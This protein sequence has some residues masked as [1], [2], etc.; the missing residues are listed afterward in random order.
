M[1]NI[2]NRFERGLETTTNTTA[3]NNGAANNSFMSDDDFNNLFHT[4][5][6]DTTKGF[7]DGCYDALVTDLEVTEGSTYLKLAVEY[8]GISKNTKLKIFDVSKF[9]CQVFLSAGL[10]LANLNEAIGKKIK[11][12]VVDNKYSVLPHMPA[13]GE[14]QATLVAPGVVNLAPTKRAFYFQWT[15]NGATYYDFD[16][17]DQNKF[18]LKIGTILRA[19]GINAVTSREDIFKF[20]G[21]SI[22]VYVVKAEGY[23]STFLNYEKRNVVLPECASDEKNDDD[24]ERF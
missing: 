1:K 3:A 12:Y 16:M 17:F 10:R 24:I 9:C 5:T 15:I 6:V 23:K 14:Y 7:V 21:K 19:F 8:N 18:N 4:G 13:V 20:I 22:P 2:K 11:L